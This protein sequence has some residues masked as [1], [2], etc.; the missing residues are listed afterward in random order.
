MTVSDPVARTAFYC[1]TLRADDAAGARPVCGDTFA[2]RFVDDDVRRELEPLLRRRA[3][4][5]S[6]VARHRIIDDLIR[7]C[8]ARDPDRRIV[9]LGAGFDTRAFRLDGGR[10]WEIDDPNLL[11]L[12]EERLPAR[13]A[14]N[15]LTRIPV[16][17]ET[18]T[19]ATHLA[20]LAGNDGALVVVEGVTMY[21]GD[22]TLADLAPRSAPHCRAAR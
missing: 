22:E 7:G 18:D 15:P 9:L 21:L 11:A 3:P 19:L 12:K 6:N 14:P 1:C 5:V 13:T 10:W 16:S 2:S 20:P 8:L 4:A 17:F